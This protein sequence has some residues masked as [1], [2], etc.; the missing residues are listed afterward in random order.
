M[1]RARARR[2]GGRGS[3]ARKDEGGVCSRRRVWDDGA[4][5]SSE[6][7]ATVEGGE[8]AVHWGRVGWSRGG[9][10]GGTGE[11][12]ASEGGQCP[13]GTAHGI[14]AGGRLLRIFDAGGKTW[15]AVV[16]E[17]GLILEFRAFQKNYSPSGEPQR[18]RDTERSRGP[19]VC[20]VPSWFK[21]GFRFGQ[22]L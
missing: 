10:A 5:G 4:P 18:R 20:S 21:S 1:E 14:E 9:A 11:R 13:A 17:C 15:N 6:A 3:R 22:R 12:D 7:N 2:G 19:S 8:V 16:E